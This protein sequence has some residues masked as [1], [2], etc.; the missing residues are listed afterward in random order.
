MEDRKR[1]ALSATDDIAPPSKR[2]QINGGA[3]AAKDDDS[4]EDAWI[5]EYTRGAIYRQMQEYKRTCNTLEARLEEMERRSAHHDDHLRVVDAWWIQLLQELKNLAEKTIPFQPDD[6]EQIFPTHTTFK[7]LQEL[8]S[9]LSKKASVISEMA[10]SIFARLVTKRPIE[11]NVATLESQVNKLLAEQKE[12]LV[13][14]NRLSSEK[15]GVSDQLNTATLR[16]MKAER[17]M[18]RLKSSQVQ[19]LEQQALA[20]STARPAGPDHENGVTE[21]NGNSAE[22]QLKLKEA[23]AVSDK[24]KQQLETALSESKKLQEELTTLQ[25]RLT[26]LTDEDYARTDAFKS[27]KSRQDDLV[28]KINLLESQNKRLT[29]ANT[30]LEAERS[31]YKKRLESEAQQLTTELEDQLQQSDTNL[32]RV[33]VIRDELHQ[34]VQ[35]LQGSKEQERIA[36]EEM[37]SLVSANEDCIRQLESQVQRLTSS[38]DVD[39]TPRPDVESLAVDDLREK[40]KKLERDFESINS[41]LPAMAAAVKKYQILANKKVYDVVAVEDR[42]SV[43]LAEKGKANQKYFD[44]R[45]NHDALNEELKKVRMHNSKNS[46]VISQL[47]ENENQSRALVASL[48]KQIA[49]L[50]QANAAMV[51]ETKRTDANNNE[52]MKRYEALRTQITELSNLAKTKDTATAMA[53]ERASILE[54]ENEK[55]KVRLESTSKDRDKWKVKSLSNSSEEEEMLRK[56]ATC[57]VCHNNF[58]N[59]ALKTCGHI[60]CRSCID[61]RISNR[62]RKCPNCSKMFDKLDVMTVHL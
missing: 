22:L 26:G 47:K 9:H 55:L 11:P 60:F 50:K 32:A 4:K 24:Q 34:E 8:E 18:D 57:S 44:A 45:R 17:K 3:N 27:F 38:E 6:K 54:T 49:D 62:M 30:K 13:K 58:K 28:K 20:S 56:L 31:S 51:L 35:K 21:V 25:A 15:E 61:D 23:T 52:M 5:E 36:L 43:A 40:Y 1:P 12:F 16:Y 48:E 29:D 42:I 2:Q 37:K 41:E 7:D 33:R 39:M 46:E 14:I 19:K 59:T 53:R 10:D